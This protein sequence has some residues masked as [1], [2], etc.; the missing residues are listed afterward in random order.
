MPNSNSFVV[1][2]P[3]TPEDFETY[4]HLRYEVLRKPWGHAPGS[5]K[6]ETDSSSIH[7]FIKLNG[8]AVAISRMHFID[9]HTAQ[10]RYMGVDPGYQGKGLGK[11]VIK[12]LEGKAIEHKRKIMVLHARENAVEFYKSCGYTVKET[13]YLLWGQIPHWLMEKNLEK[14]GR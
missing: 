14:N 4:Y 7:A 11:L 12:Y 9:E 3:S 1:S 8:K 13:S 5:E 2:E 10:I 6:D